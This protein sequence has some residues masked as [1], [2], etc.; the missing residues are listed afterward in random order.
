MLLSV[1]TL[2]IVFV[3]NFVA[4]GDGVG[5]C[6][7]QLSPSRC[8]AVLDCRR[9]YRGA[10]R[11]C[12]DDARLLDP[13]TPALLLIPLLIGGSL[14]VLAVCLAAMGIRR[15]FGAPVSWRTTF[16]CLGVNIV[17]LSYFVWHD[18]MTM[19]I[20]I[21]S[22]CQVVP[23]AMTL[24]LLMARRNGRTH[25]G[26]QWTAWIAIL[27]IAIYVMR[28]VA[29][30]LNIGGPVSLIDFNQFQ[31]VL[32]L[33]LVFLS[34]MWNCGFLLMGIDRLRAEVA[35]L[36][37]FDD[38]TGVA[39]RR[40]LL[41]R[42]DEECARSYR[43]GEVFALLMIDLDGF[44]DINDANGH[45]AGDECLRLF[46]PRRP[47][48]AA[49]GR[50]PGADGRRRVLRGAAVDHVARRRDGRPPMCWKP[51]RMKSCTG[52]ARRWRCPPPSASRN[53]GPRSPCTRNGCSPP[54]TGRSTWPRRTARTAMRCST[55]RRSRPSRTCA[56]RP[57][58][59]A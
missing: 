21:Y 45:A 3:I 10:R 14:L 58:A 37:L 48:P 9:L 46:T 2:W 19:R 40:Q 53:G 50:P 32:I 44:K 59:T 56:R 27:M 42:L 5:L 57:D 36:A 33:S 54:P 52:T 31:A 13:H 18:N 24:P 4:L 16:L 28:S 35:D 6:R 29:A 39:N 1:P 34:M 25:P 15:F 12:G 22:A 38:L 41:V 8:R 20:L 7:P 23:I 11:C 47:K 43:S 51:A 55:P 30:L 49:Q 17:G 26:A